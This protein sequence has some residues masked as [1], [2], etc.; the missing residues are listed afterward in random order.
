MWVIFDAV[1]HCRPY[2][3][4]AESQQVLFSC[5]LASLS[6]LISW[7]LLGETLVDT[8]A[9]LTLPE[10][11]GEQVIK[12]LLLN[13]LPIVIGL[14]MHCVS[15][16]HVTLHGYFSIMSQS[17]AQHFISQF[18]FPSSFSSLWFCA[19]LSC[20][21]CCKVTFILSQKIE[22]AFDLLN[23]EDAT[24]VTAAVCRV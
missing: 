6:P 9:L 2:G 17:S 20:L 24:Q 1:T 4:A 3:S 23:G 18:C 13:A 11:A 10:G 12:P 5:Q 22:G 14:P 16:L 19:S 7:M 15:V 21:G 8:S